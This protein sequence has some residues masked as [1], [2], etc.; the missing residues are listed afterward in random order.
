MSEKSPSYLEQK[1]KAIITKENGYTFTFH[2]EKIKLHDAI[3]IDLIN[4]M[5][6]SFQKD[7]VMTDDDLKIIIY[8]PSSYEA[9]P[10]IYEKDERS[11]WLLAFQLVKK[12]KNHQLARLHLVVCPDNIVFDRSLE[13]SFLHYGV[14]E[15]LP[16]YEKDEEKLFQETKATVAAIVEGKHLFEE[17]Y[18]FYKSL[19]F[20]SLAKELM[21]KE[22]FDMLEEFI[23]EEII[24]L[25]KK[26]KTFI[27]IPEKKWKVHRYVT[28][29][30]FICFIPAFIYTLYSVFFQMPKQQ[31]YVESNEHFLNREYS[32]VVNTLARYDVEGMPDVVKYSL[33]TS[34]VANESLTEKQKERVQSRITLHSDPKYYEYWIYLGRGENEEALEI[35]RFLED[36]DLIML[37]LINYRE[38]IKTNDDLKSEERQQKLDEIQNELDEYIKE[39]EQQEK[40]EQQKAERE[41]EKQREKAIQQK[42]LE[43]QQETK[44]GDPAAEGKTTDQVT[45]PNE[46]KE[47][48]SKPDEDQAP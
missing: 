28:A 6:R 3:E 5:D 31:A 34:Y 44:K 24:R 25:E 8:P 17:Y 48:E 40:E 43:S 38:E 42:Q 7:I 2:K 4:E 11:K 20:S 41:K 15:S 21:S 45:T 27:H 16:P 47:V 14:K 33:A 10:S 9:F 39:K 32:E 22:N 13:P 23:R 1:L 46:T 19:E 35:A 36:R 12:V 26:D 30:L 18:Y 29:G 37:G